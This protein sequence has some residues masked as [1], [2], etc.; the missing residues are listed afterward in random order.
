MNTQRRLDFET[1]Q[2]LDTLGAALLDRIAA[3]PR[4]RHEAGHC[5]CAADLATLKRMEDLRSRLWPHNPS[6]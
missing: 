6:R 1:V 3:C 2:L 4:R 5:S